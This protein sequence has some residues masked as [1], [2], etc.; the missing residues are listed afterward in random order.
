MRPSIARLGLIAA[1]TV[2]MLLGGCM[3]LT[4][5]ARVRA[6]PGAITLLRQGSFKVG[7]TTIGTRGESSLSCDHGHVEYQVPVAPQAARHVSAAQ[8]ERCS[9]AA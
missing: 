6:G 7:G 4:N 2:A 1:S 3:P 5:V 9:L 8:F